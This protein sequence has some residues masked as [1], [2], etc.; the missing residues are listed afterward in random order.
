VQCSIGMAAMRRFRSTARVAKNS[1]WLK[2]FQSRNRSP[3]TGDG[4]FFLAIL[5]IFRAARLV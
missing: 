4:R 2:L 3:I 5:A 1:E